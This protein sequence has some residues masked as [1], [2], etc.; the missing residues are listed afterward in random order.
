VKRVTVKNALAYQ[1]KEKNTTVKFLILDAHVKCHA[2][3]YY[4]GK[5]HCTVDLLFDWF[6]VSCMA[7]D[8]ICFYL[9]N[10]LIQTSQ[11]GGQQYSDTSPFSIP[12]PYNTIVTKTAKLTFGYSALKSFTL[13]LIS[14][15][16]LLCGQ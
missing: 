8:N 10:R 9:Q 13:Y 14:F 15:H 11:T 5:Y 2:R 3:K 12:W 7:I 4:R 6:G 1:A 16:T